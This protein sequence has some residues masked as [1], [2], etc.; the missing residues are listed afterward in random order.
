M[1]KN[2]Q[3]CS[4]FAKQKISEKLLQTTLSLF[5]SMSKACNKFAVLVYAT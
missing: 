1:D 3:L 5:T 4:K 2:I